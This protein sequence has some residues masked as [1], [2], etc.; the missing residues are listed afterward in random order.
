MQIDKIDRLSAFKQ[1]RENWDD[2]YEADPQAHFFLSWIWLLGW[3]PIVHESWFILAAKPNNDSSYVAFFPLKTLIEYKSGGFETTISMIGNSMADYTG[4]VC[5]PNYETKVIPAFAAYIQQQL[6][7]CSFD[8]KSILATDRRIPLFLQNFDDDSDRFKLSQLRVQSVNR[9]D[10]DNYIAPYV[11]L[12]DSWDSYLQSHLSSNTR[13]KIR[14]FLRKVENSNQFRITQVN[15]NNL[16]SQIEI[17]LGF[18]GARWGKQ[19]GDNYDVVINYYRLI[20]HHCF[21]HDCLYLPVLWQNDRPLGAIANFADVRQKSMLFVIAGR[22]MSVK[23]P[24]SGLILHANAIRYAIANGYK[25][26][27]FLMGDEEYKYSFG[28]NERH[29]KHIAIENNSYHHQPHDSE[30]ILSLALRHAV[31]HHR[32]NRANKAELG[33]RR[34][35]EIDSNCNEALYGLAV[36]KRQKEEYRAAEKLLDKLLQIQPDYF[37]AWF[38]LGNLYQTQGRLAEAIQAYNRVIKLQ[39]DAIAAYNNLGYAL[40]QQGKWLEAIA[41]YQKALELQPECIEAE[42]NHAN[43]LYALGKLTSDKQKHYA[44]L[45][46]DLGFQCKQIGDFKTAI[47]Y[48][49][50]SLDLNPNFSEARENLSLLQKQTIAVRS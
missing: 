17:L 48:Y 15:S 31:K 50:Q 5:L 45:N 33:Y 42:V 39:P 16:K 13:Q 36:L 37:K 44:R 43:V 28:V 1:V 35:L 22:D 29:I 25:I 24:P 21:Q 10:P 41:C 7:W 47:A 2:V 32:A 30:Q 49:Q 20:L 6:S 38:S 3:L 8:L 11:S 14:R 26:Y 34:I 4:L 27:D 46:N 23:N 12:P 18:W 40:Q 19:M 9:E